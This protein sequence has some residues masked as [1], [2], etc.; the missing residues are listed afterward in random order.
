MNLDIMH[1]LVKIH[2]PLLTTLQKTKMLKESVASSPKRLL[3]IG[4]TFSASR[5][6]LTAVQLDLFFI[7][8]EPKTAEEIRLALNLRERG[9]PDF[10]YCPVEVDKLRE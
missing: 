10:A 7:L 8:Q 1:I 2:D 9:F 3:D 6:L 5:V 4:H